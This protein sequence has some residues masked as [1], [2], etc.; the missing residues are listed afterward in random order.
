MPAVEFKSSVADETGKWTKGVKFGHAK[1]VTAWSGPGQRTKPVWSKNPSDRP[2]MRPLDDNNAGA[3]PIA[4]GI[5]RAA[6][7]RGP[8]SEEIAGRCPFLGG[9]APH[10]NGQ[11][12]R[13]GPAV[14]N[15]RQRE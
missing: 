5:G 3:R 8:G 10:G 15:A 9:C 4:R 11:R 13:S 1:A 6:H 7:D 12:I 2:F 14:P